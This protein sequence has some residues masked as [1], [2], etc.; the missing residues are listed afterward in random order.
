[1]KVSLINNAVN[2]V[3]AVLLGAAFQASRTEAQ[4]DDPVVWLNEGMCNLS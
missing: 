1:M 3:L 4:Q 2:L